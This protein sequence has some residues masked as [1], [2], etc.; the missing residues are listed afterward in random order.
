MTQLSL[1][2]PLVSTQW[3]KEHLDH[4]QLVI[5]DSSSYMPGNPR[6]AY[7]EWQ[8]KRIKNSHFF[9]F[10]HKVCD[11]NSDLPHMLPSTEVFTKEMQAL[12]VNNDSIIVVYDS[13]GIFSAPRAW[14][15]LTAMGHRNCAVLD[16]GLPE[17]LN[18]KGECENNFSEKNQITKGNFIA[19]LAPE[20]IK[21]KE[22]ILNA[23]NNPT[24]TILDARSRER[25]YGE[26]PEPRAGLTGGHIPSSENLP[27]TDLLDN[28]K[29]KPLSEL[30]ALIEEKANK[31]QHLYASCGSGVTA[32]VI[33]FAAFLCKYQ[34]IAVYDGSWSEWGQ[35]DLQLPITTD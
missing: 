2:G 14:W 28:G 22:Q 31:D 7:Q 35:P 10:N 16:G 12:G 4:P 26:A 19:E 13:Q 30:N 27:F 21:D 18:L 11:L 3:L 32:C 6:D 9:D 33:A 1:P 25:F 5:L 20:W 8:Q 29:L 24:I 17:W 34:K 23:I 15:M